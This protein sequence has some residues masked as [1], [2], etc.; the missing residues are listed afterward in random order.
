M[1]DG[2]VLQS[3]AHK[4]RPDGQGH[5]RAFFSPS[6]GMMVVKTNPNSASDAKVKS[7]QTRHR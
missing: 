7:R 4:I 5:V 6:Q 2:L 3:L 1:P